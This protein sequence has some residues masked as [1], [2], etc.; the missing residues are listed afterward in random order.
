MMKNNKELIIKELALLILSIDEKPNYSDDTLVFATIIFQ[1]VFVDKM[2][3]LQQVENLSQSDREAMVETAGS[4]LRL[5][6][7]KY[8]NLDLHELAK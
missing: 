7:K 2:W 6:I 3:D 8:T 1:N 5:F 4:E